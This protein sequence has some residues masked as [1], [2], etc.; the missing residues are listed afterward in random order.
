MYRDSWEPS[1]L[2]VRV[3]DIKY[4]ASIQA[5]SDAATEMSGN[6]YGIHCNVNLS[7]I[8][9]SR[10]PLGADDRGQSLN[11]ALF[12]HHRAHARRPVFSGQ[13]IGLFVVREKSP[14]LRI[15]GVI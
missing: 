8:P 5:G 14:I 3:S 10:W 4:R 1:W 11:Y 15:C 12:G 6:E 9:T 13:Q 7:W 2:R